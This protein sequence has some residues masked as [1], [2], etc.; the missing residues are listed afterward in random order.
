MALY[1]RPRRPPAERGE[2]VK[3]DTTIRDA[4][5]RWFAKQQ[6]PKLANP[7]Q[8]ARDAVRSARARIA[9]LETEE[10]K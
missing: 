7:A 8:I 10:R 9:A 6:E 3:T 4:I 1:P 2:A 5:R